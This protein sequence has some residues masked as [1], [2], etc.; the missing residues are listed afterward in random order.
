MKVPLVT[1]A[2]KKKR[3]QTIREKRRRRGRK[4]RPLPPAKAGADNAYKEFKVGY[5]YDEEKEHR[6]V[7]VTAGNHE[8]AGRMLNAWAIRSGW[9]RPRSESR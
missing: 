3:R 8:A 2:E 1:D 4:C 5:L 7:G 6:L 9:L